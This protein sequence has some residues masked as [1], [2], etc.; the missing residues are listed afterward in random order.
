MLAILLLALVVGGT[1]GCATTSVEPFTALAASAQQLRDG[2]DASLGALHDRT[3]DRH[4]AEAASGDLDRI[5]ALLLAQPSGDPFGW[6]SPQP[7]LF[8]HV[9]RFREG[10]Y[11]LNTVLVGYA[12]LLAQLASPDL[13][14]P[15][16]FDQ[17]AADLNANLR[18]AVQAFGVQ[19]PPNKEVA[20]FST[21]ASGAF[22]VY[23]QNKQRGALVKALQDNQAAIDDTAELGAAAVRVTAAALRNEYEL[24]SAS[25]AQRKA[26]RELIDLDDRFIKEMAG[27]RTLHQA[28]QAL[29][30][31][32]RELAAGAGEP[33]PGFPL[34]REIYEKGRALYRLYE[35]L[36]KDDRK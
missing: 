31:A 15:A 11:Q 13:L 25:L 18:T 16:T 22:R 20:V 2:A 21:A 8:L 34:I 1:A 27:L 19:A 5:Q 33:Q 10:V 4:I 7:P 24:A 9:A 36:A 14:K 30:A 29:P 32:H 26:I 23:L 3:R 35:Q 17:L 28:Y 12:G 6:V